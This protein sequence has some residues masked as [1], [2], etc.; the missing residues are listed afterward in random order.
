MLL[1]TISDSSSQWLVAVA[2]GALIARLLHNKYGNGLA[3]VPGPLLAGYTDLWRFF[4]VLGRRPELVYIALHEKH[5]DVVRVGPRALSFA[6][7]AAAKA[8]Y[9]INSGFTKS[10]FYP[11]QRTLA[12]GHEV[13]SLFNIQDEHL[14]A[15]LKRQVSSAYAMSTLVQFEPLVDS[16]ACLLVNE[17]SNR[18]AGVK[19]DEGIC[20]LGAWLQY[21]AF[22]V[23]GQLMA[24][25]L[26]YA[27]PVGQ[28]PILDQWLLKNPRLA[29]NERP[30]HQDFLCRFLE[31]HEKDPN[32]I[33][34]HR[35]LSLAVSNVFAGSDTTAV[36]LRAIFYHLL[37]NPTKLQA[38][39]NEIHEAEKRG[40]LGSATTAPWKVVHGLPYLSA[41]I[42]E[43]LRNHPAV[44]L[45]L[46]R[47]TPAD[48]AVLCGLHVPA[49]VIVGCHAWVVHRN[50]IFGSKPDTFRPERWIESPP[51]R[52]QLMQNSLLSFGGGSRTCIG[53]NI[54][55]LEIYKVVPLI[56]RN[57]EAYRRKKGKDTLM[58][59]REI[60]SQVGQAVED[61][62]EESFDIFCEELPSGNLGFIDSQAD[63]IDITVNGRDFAIKQSP[64]ILSSSRA[65]GTTGAVLWKITPLVADWLSD[66]SNFLWKTSILSPDST[67]AELGCGIS[68]LIPLTL[69]PMV[70]NCIVTDQEYVHKLLKENLQRNY[71]CGGNIRD[72][73]I[74]DN[75]TAKTTDR[76]KPPRQPRSTRSKPHKQTQA[77]LWERTGN[78]AFTPLDWETDYP[79]ELRQVLKPRQ[80]QTRP[81][82]SMT[83]TPTGKIA[84][85]TS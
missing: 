25:M 67:V 61:A 72:R 18:F 65:G 64:T 54:S 73:N 36:T 49:G 30:D 58:E 70:Q 15:K 17:L 78:I 28:I 37:R 60:L 74:R 80:P 76:N 85:L 22:D 47:V 5:G 56:L 75:R 13:Q 55:L 35:V 39:L 33:T 20:D 81:Q 57:F 10:D 7:P 44:G 68:G 63:E 50:E 41:V 12:Q 27:A 71:P 42:T 14:H 3:H 79:A 23:I 45:P 51:E 2:F 52:S 6:D 9:A 69:A 4:I 11:V 82:T 19:G 77:F 24:R 46:E 83:T 53:K 34:L 62:E 32:F 43:A 26:D 48:G 1:Q 16:T 21:Y 59:L 84:D 66:N 40:D 8:I 29:S 31:L 38:L